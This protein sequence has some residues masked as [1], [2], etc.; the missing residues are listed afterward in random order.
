[1]PKSKAKVA[2][3]LIT[4][5]DLLKFQL[6]GDPQISPDGKWIVF[7]KSHVDDKNQ[8]VTNLWIVST[9]GGDARQFTS[10]GK[11]G[12]AKWSPDGAK[13]A[14]ISG[15]DKPTSQIFVISLAG[16]EAVALTKFPEGSIESFDWS[17]DGRKM[18]VKFREQE[19]EYTKKAEEERKEKGL[20]TPARVI[21]DVWYRLD[22]DGYFNTARHKLYLVDVSSGDHSKIYDKDT[23][24]WFSFSWAPDSKSM[25]IAANTSK[26]PFKTPWK[27]RIYILDIR[28]GKVTP[29]PGQVDGSVEAPQFSPDGRKIAYG[30]REGKESQWGAVNSHLHV[31]DVKTGKRKNLTG[32]TDYCLHAATLSD[33]RE[34]G[35]GANFKWSPDGKRVILSLGWHGETHPASIDAGGGKIEW[36]TSGAKEC[37]F[38]SFS[39]NGIFGMT[40]GTWDRPNEIAVGKPSKG[41]LEVTK[42]T[43][44]NGKFFEEIELSKPESFSTK[45]E[46]GWTVHGWFLKPTRGKKAKSP[47][48]L[49]VHGGPHAQY[50]VPFFHELQVLAASGYMVFYANPRGSKGYGEEHCNAIKGDWGNKDWMDVMAV[51]DFMAKRNDVDE[52]RMSIMGGSYGGYMTCWAIGH[53]NRFKAAITDR[54]VS[55]LVSMAGNSDF[56]DIPDTYWKGNAWDQSETLWAQSPIKYMRNAKTPTLI[57]HSE[58]DLRCNVEQGEQVFSALKILGVPTRLV[59]YPSSTSHGMSRSGPPDLRIHRLGQILS[60]YREYLD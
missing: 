29:V 45:S 59:R 42:L 30:G 41:K 37:S 5:E 26:E 54:C 28:S 11:D 53:T 44:F 17:P 1:M 32:D 3:R 34:A 35:F 21:D 55:N 18:A 36:L 8:K 13:V 15:R 9:S 58:G 52:K 10:G 39:N 25:A 20:S 56:P 38:A 48:V 51:A 4:P 22:G 19:A 7:A 31:I 33:T 14:F 40:V 60:W 57:I 46:D 12:G 49:E 23:M 16:G 50:G 6:V 43:D 27:D 2:K 47:A 24:G